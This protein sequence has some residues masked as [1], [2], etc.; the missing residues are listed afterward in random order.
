MN[1]ARVPVHAATSAGVFTSARSP[2]DAILTPF[3]LE[4]AEQEL[5]DTDDSATLVTAAGSGARITP[6]VLTIH[7]TFTG[8]ERRRSGSGPTLQPPTSPT[9][10]QQQQTPC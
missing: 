4:A 1:Y 6:C 9:M 8:V 7:C 5:I 2:P 10:H 3:H